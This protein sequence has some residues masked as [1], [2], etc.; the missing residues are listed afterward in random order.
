MSV[1]V[2][3][4]LPISSQLTAIQDGTKTLESIG[5]DVENLLYMNGSSASTTMTGAE[6]TLLE[7][8]P[9]TLAQFEGGAIDLT[10]M[11][12]GDTIII[13]IYKKIKSDGNYIQQSDNIINTYTG[14]QVPALKDI[15]GSPIKYGLKITATQSAGTNRVIDSL[16]FT[17]APG[18]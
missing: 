9:T 8:I 11:D 6:L 5:T 3:S 10:N 16:W 15:G 12:A 7:Y 18:V 1:G 14:A 17:S 4:L 13:K 2:K